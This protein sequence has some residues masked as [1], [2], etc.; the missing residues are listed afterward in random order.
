MDLDELDP[1]SPP[2]A[3]DDGIAYLASRLSDGDPTTLLTFAWLCWVRFVQSALQPG[4]WSAPDDLDRSVDAYHRAVPALRADRYVEPEMLAGVLLTYANVVHTRHSV[5]GDV[6]DLDRSIELTR[7]AVRLAGEPADLPALGS[8]SDRY[9]DRYR[10]RGRDDDFLAAERTLRAALAVTGTDPVER[11]SLW[12]RLGYLYDARCAATSDS[13]YRDRSIRVLGTGWREGSGYPLLGM[14]YADSLVER[15]RQT[16]GGELDTALATL[17]AVDVGDLPVETRAYY[18]HLVMEAHFLRH[19]PGEVD[20]LLAAGRAATRYIDDPYAEEGL[21]AQARVIRATV[22]LD[23]LY[24]TRDLTGDLDQ[25]VDD[26]RAA[27]DRVG[28]EL[29]RTADTQLARALSERARRTSDPGHVAEATAFAEAALARLPDGTANQAEVRYHLGFLLMMAV[30]AGRAGPDALDR[31]IGLFRGVVDGTVAVPGVRAAAGAQLAA[32]VIGRMFYVGRGGPGDLDTAIAALDSALRTGPPDDVNRFAVAV[33]LA[34]TLMVR[35]ELRGDLADLHWCRKLLADV[36]G[37]APNDPNRHE[38]A[39]GFAQVELAYCVATGR[40]PDRDLLSTLAGA[41]AGVAPGNVTRIQL[42]RTL[43]SGYTIRAEATRDPDEAATALRYAESVLSE[44]PAHSPLAALMRAS[45]AG[46]LLLVGRTRDDTALVRRAVTVLAALVDDAAMPQR[47]R[48]LGMY[49]AALMELCRRESDPALLDRA[50]AVLTEATALAAAQPGTRGSAEIAMSLVAASVRTKDAARVADAGRAAL[51]AHAWQVLLQSGTHEAMVAARQ[52]ATDA[53]RV[54][55]ALLRAGDPRGACLALE[56]GRGL[57]LHAATV[58]ATV[59]DLLRRAGEPDLARE[60]AAAS[61]GQRASSDWRSAAPTVPSDLRFR[62]LRALREESTLFDPPSIE[63]VCKA[64]SAVGADCLVYVF[65]GVEDGAGLALLVHADGRLESL[66]LPDLVGDWSVPAAVQ[67]VTRDVRP[68]PGHSVTATVG[69]NLAEA[70]TAAWDVAVGPILDHW[71]GASP[72]EPRMVLVLGGSLATVPWH[73]AHSG[74]GR[75]WAIDEA[76]L[77]YIASGRLLVDLADRDVADPRG[78]ALVIGN[79]DTD[80]AGTDLPGAGDEASTIF[81]RYYAAGRFCGQPVGSGIPVGGR[82]TPQDVIDWLDGSGSVLHLACHGV[83]SAEGPASSL[84][85]L[86]DGSTVSAEEILRNPVR[87]PCGVV[88]LAAC[89]THRAGRAYDEAVTLATAFLVA[90]VATSIG[91]L[92]PVPDDGTA[93]LM[94]AFHGNLV[95]GGMPPRQALRAAQ[96]AM[97]DA[98][99]DAGLAEWAGFVHLGR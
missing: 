30:E 81:R 46:A 63:A 99:G 91:S 80:G 87:R 1:N 45:A 18:H 88:T 15:G 29:R 50:V 4:R 39:L 42:L 89:T 61:H 6:A 38:L 94:V 32:G 25:A 58:A 26:L 59:P 9:V 54:A 73:A 14:A 28:P 56:T 44:V 5:T 8:I 71:Y 2:G 49:G 23:H 60:W 75:R 40:T 10:I 27:G 31:A 37:E 95:D 77:S 98:G 7:E 93:R 66:D 48:Y 34:N 84:L 83:V 64:V 65:P 24:I 97:R 21:R 72:R 55:R 85:L 12:L 22:R 86:A 74:D 67:S 20:D 17:A 16:K 69:R 47:E 57:V 90:G 41:L 13:S 33:S 3:V 35:F 82:G 70:C 52:S 68:P 11:A 43:A 78:A 79:P 53:L 36:R 96:R 51:T 19:V 92:W 62:A 76:E